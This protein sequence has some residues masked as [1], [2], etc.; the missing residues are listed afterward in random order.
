VLIPRRPTGFNGLPRR[1]HKA[2]GGIPWFPLTSAKSLEDLELILRPRI[3]VL[4]VRASP[5]SLRLARKLHAP[6]PEAQSRR[7]AYKWWQSNRSP[8]KSPATLPESDVLEPSG[9][10][11]A[12]IYEKPPR[13]VQ[14]DVLR[15]LAILLVLNYHQLVSPNHAGALRPLAWAWHQIGWSGVDLFFVLSGFLIGGL[16]FQE[17]RNHGRLDVRRFIIRRGFKIWPCYLIYISFLFLLLGLTG[18]GFGEAAKTLLPNFFHVQNYLKGPRGHTWSLAVEEHFYL[19]LPLLLLLLSHR[20]SNLRSYLPALP[21]I[22][23]AVFVICLGLRWAI[24]VYVEDF[25]NQGRW[26]HYYPTHMRIDSLFFG[27][28]LAYFYHVRPVPLSKLARHRLLFLLAAACLLLPLVFWGLTTA[29]W[30]SVIGY[31]MAYLGYGFIVLIV[32]Y[33]PLGEGW[34]GRLL[35]GRPARVLAFIGVYS[36]PIYLWHIDAAQ[37]RLQDLFRAGWL[38]QFPAEVRWCTFMA[39]YVLLAT[40]AGV[41][42]GK[43]VER[44]ALALR[45]RLF[46][47]RAQPLAIPVVGVRGCSLGEAPMP[48]CGQLVAINQAAPTVEVCN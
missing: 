15:G 13:L 17:L 33:T 32:V 22:A 31:T 35:A 23:S 3:C 6:S 41:I 43:V 42:A 12:E 46:P 11:P 28:L 39:L 26:T 40:A 48:D 21:W 36:Y 44:P 2:A 34:L 37:E 18:G 8:Q 25:M 27:V 38:E 1:I 29:A 16:L 9:L 19:A 10:C 20:R 7:D 24:P 5:Q 30:V 14:L 45:D 47:S 4:R